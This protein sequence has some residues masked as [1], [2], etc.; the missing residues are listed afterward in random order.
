MLGPM[1]PYGPESPWRFAPGLT[2][3]L[4][5]GYMWVGDAYKAALATSNFASAPLNIT[6]NGLTTPVSGLN[7]PD[8]NPQNVST[9]AARVRYSF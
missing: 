4:A 2:F 3:D 1:R 9:I 8:T 5:A 7:R 6:A